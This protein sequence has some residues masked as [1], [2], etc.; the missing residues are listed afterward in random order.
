MVLHY[1]RRPFPC[2]AQNPRIFSALSKDIAV[3][4]GFPPHQQKNGKLSITTICNLNL[5]FKPDFLK[6]RLGNAEI[7]CDAQKAEKVAPPVMDF[8]NNGASEP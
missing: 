3:R 4:A 6:I 5:G 2:Q 1:S 8:Q 7:V